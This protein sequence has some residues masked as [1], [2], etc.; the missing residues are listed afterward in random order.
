MDKET[1]IKELE[2]LGDLN[3]Q[4]N[5]IAASVIYTLAGLLITNDEGLIAIECERITDIFLTQLRKLNT[6][7]I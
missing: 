5:P 6:N 2:T 4:S 7:E 3:A 1:L